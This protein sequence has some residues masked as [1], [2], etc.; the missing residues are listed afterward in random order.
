MSWRPN[1]RISINGLDY[2]GQTIGQVS[3]NRGRRTVY[4]RPNA[5]YA[6]IELIDVDGIAPFVVGDDVRI[7]ID[8][9]NI[10]WQFLPSSWSALE[11]GWSVLTTT[12]PQF[13]ST[14]VF[15]GVLSDWSVRTVATGGRPVLI[16]RLQAVGPLARL[17]RRQVLAAGR[18]SE[19][20]GDRVLAA[21]ASGLSDAW[22]E[23]DVSLEFQDATGTW[24]EFGGFVRPDLID[25]GVY[26]VSALGTADGGYNALQV[27]QD[28]G[29]S[30][31]GILFET[32]DGFVGYADADRR[33][34]NEL[35]GFLEIPAA[36]LSEDGVEVSQRLADITNRV[37]VEYE[38]G[39][40]QADDADS[41]VQYGLFESAIRTDLVNLSNAEARA[42][43]FVL[44][45]AEPEL[46][47][48]QLD[49][50]LLAVPTV[51]RDSLVT[52][53]SND[54]IRVT[55]LPEALGFTTFDGF[56]EGVGWRIDPFRADLTLTVSD[57]N[58]SVG[59]LRW[60]QVGGTVTWASVGT[61]V[62][63]ADTRVVFYA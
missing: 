47:L 23:L 33:L 48:D 21:V 53:G 26:T 2:T 55:G 9:T 57:R 19:D 16:Y 43:D 61:A 56:V 44:R 13:T 45:H 62:T 36:L 7:S 59:S 54:Y 15:A 25:P 37:T 58:L 52:T 40:V 1:P 30:G 14:P 34:A 49:V 42:E 22:E 12:Q 4:E 60:G 32:A 29:F 10:Q 24:S 39:A 51:L 5:G 46:V 17:N 41:I 63:W 27:A 38:G 11:S 20:D 6:S 8:V 18:P 35:A 50:N 3:I 28:A 31:E